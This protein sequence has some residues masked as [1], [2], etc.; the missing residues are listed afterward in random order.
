MDQI[1]NN[2]TVK[3]T[4]KWHQVRRRKEKGVKKMKEQRFMVKNTHFCNVENS[5]AILRNG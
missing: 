3:I 4:M 5:L 2:N 1:E